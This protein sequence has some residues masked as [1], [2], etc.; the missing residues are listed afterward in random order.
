MNKANMTISE[1]I[2]HMKHKSVN[3]K[4]RVHDENDKNYEW[5][6][7][8]NSDI[9]SFMNSVLYNKISN[10]LIDSIIP[11]ECSFNLYVFNEV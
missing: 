11:E 9:G 5:N 4:I 6:I 3:I 1:F 7:I 2:S 10:Y 8:F